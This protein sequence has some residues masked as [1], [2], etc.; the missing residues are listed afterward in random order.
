MGK[1]E[2]LSLTEGM[3]PADEDSAASCSRPDPVKIDRYTILR[4]LGEGG[5]GQVFL[6]FDDDLDRSVAIK[7]PRPQR[8]A[9][10]EYVEAYLT[11][12]RI[13]ASLDHPHI[14]PVYDVAA[15]TR[16]CFSWYPSSSKEATSNEK[17]NRIAPRS[18]SR[19]KWSLSLPRLC[20]MPTREVWFTHPA[21]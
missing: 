2:D 9:R 21:G 11:E 5:F 20:I 10:P 1:A 12:A 17:T 6:A 4:R 19:R 16:V 7:V 13:V 18:S 15:P 14:V 8:V 3:Q